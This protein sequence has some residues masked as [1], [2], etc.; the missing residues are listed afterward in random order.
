MVTSFLTQNNL[1]FKGKATVT[2]GHFAFTFKVPKD[3]NFQYGNGR[4][5]LYAENGV[6]DVNGLF[7]DFFVGEPVVA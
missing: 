6:K 7:S 1:L 2:N 4:L 5:S 3:I